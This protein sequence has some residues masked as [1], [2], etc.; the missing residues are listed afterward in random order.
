MRSR[1]PRGPEAAWGRR[2]GQGRRPPQN[3]R[4]PGRP[5]SPD[6]AS[7]RPCRRLRRAR[8]RWFRQASCSRKAAPAWMNSECPPETSSKQVRRIERFGQPDGERVAFEVIDR[9]QRQ[10][11]DQRNR[12]GGYKPHQQSA[13][14]AGPG[15]GGDAIEAA[16]IEMGFLQRGPDKAVEQLDMRARR[17]FGDHAPVRRVL[18]ELCAHDVRE[19]RAASVG[20]QPHDRG[21]GL[22][23]TRL[24][25]EYRKAGLFLLHMH[26]NIFADRAPLH[27]PD[28]N[29]S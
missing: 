13:D 2:N 14:Q 29:P 5:E 6:R 8:R 17:D 22:V 3:A 9:H 23:A 18:L 4:Q 27:D 28:C 20:L 24:Y 1:A 11:V 19:D 26:K 16:E 21:G 10:I 25:A 15:G 7:W 12:L